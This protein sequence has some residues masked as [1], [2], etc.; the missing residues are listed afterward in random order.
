[1][2]ILLPHT[3]SHLEP[4][5]SAGRADGKTSVHNLVLAITLAWST[6]SITT[7]SKVQITCSHPNMSTSDVSCR[8]PCSANGTEKHKEQ[9]Q[10]L[11]K[12]R[13]THVCITN[14]ANAQRASCLMTY[15]KPSALCGIGL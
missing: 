5:A 10:W 12:G 13:E 2:C 3:L 8:T 1:M 11:M 4:S 7:A 6:E 9:Q 14:A 15:T